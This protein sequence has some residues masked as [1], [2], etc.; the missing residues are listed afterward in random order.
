[1]ETLLARARQGEPLTDFPIIDLHGHLGRYNF[2]I[3]D[4]SAGSVVRVMDRVGVASVACSHMQTMGYR[5]CWGNDEV[6]A[7]MRAHPGR[8]LGYISLWPASEDAV[9]REV[10]TRVAQGFIGIK[11]HNNNG[12]PYA[13]PAY[14]PAYAIA[15]ELH[16]PLLFHTWGDEPSLRDIRAIAARHPHAPCLL[17]HAGVSAEETYLALAHDLPNIYLDTALS[18]TPNGLI[19]RLVAGAGADRVTFGSDIYFLSLPHQL[20]KILGARITD[21]EKRL[22]L[23]ENARRILDDIRGSAKAAA[24]LEDSL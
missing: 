3:P 1:M 4:L 24:N 2:A 5:A 10:E 14:A 12:F 6:L 16:L 20:G 9:R 19:E 11:L 15:H 18:Q 13:D 22:I 17:A 23:R 8:I 7:A 21:E